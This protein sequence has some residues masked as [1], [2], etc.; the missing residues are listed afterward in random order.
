M[1]NETYLGD[2]L[3]ASYD[4]WQVTLRVPRGH[5]D[6]YVCLDPYVGQAL[7]QYIEKLRSKNENTSDR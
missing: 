1:N 4:G 5:T 3:Y 6:H 2:G 7:M